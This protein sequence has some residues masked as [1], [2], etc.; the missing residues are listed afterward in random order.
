MWP[1]NLFAVSW[2][3]LDVYL[4]I[5]VGGVVAVVVV[6][7]A[8]VRWKQRPRYEVPPPAPLRPEQDAWDH[9]EKSYADQRASVRRDGA[10][11]PVVLTSP[12]F[13]G[14]VKDGY[15]LDRSTGGIRVAMESALAPGCSLQVKAENAP[16]ETPWVTVIVRSCK[17]GDKFFEHG[18]EFENT[19][20][21]NVLLLFG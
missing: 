16:P 11:V 10:P 19:P 8:F 15:V 18:C 4:P 6:T 21:W 12:T 9:L 3:D 20:P 5:M 2:T 1:H 17:K 7:V 14:G 13:R